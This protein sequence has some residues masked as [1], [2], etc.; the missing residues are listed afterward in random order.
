MHIAWRTMYTTLFESL[1]NDALFSPMKTVYV[2]SEKQLEEMK[3]K[4]RQEELDNLGSSRK[5]LEEAYQ[6]RIKVFDERENEIKEELK[7]LKAVASDEAKK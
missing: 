5:K 1:L 7:A 3:R 2:V 6:S 4:Q